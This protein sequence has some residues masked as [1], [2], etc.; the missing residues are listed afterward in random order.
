MMKW[1]AT[2]IVDRWQKDG[3][4]LLNVEPTTQADTYQGE[5]TWTFVD[6]L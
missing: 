4:V 3:G 5:L 1:R 6:N 2:E